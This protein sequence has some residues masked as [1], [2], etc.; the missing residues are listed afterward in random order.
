MIHACRQFVLASVG[1][2]FFITH[3]AGQDRKMIS[4]H[5]NGLTFDQ[6]VQE[7]ETHSDYHFYYTISKADSLTINLEVQEKPLSFVLDQV[8]ANTEFRYAIDDQGNVFITRKYKIETSLPSDFFSKKKAA[9]DSSGTTMLNETGI[10]DESKDEKLK[11]TLEN[12]L[13]LIGVRTNALKAGNAT[14]AGYIRDQKSGESISGAAV[15]IDN[16]PIGVTTDQYGYFSF[17]LPRGRHVLRISSVGMKDTKRQVMLYSDGKLNIELSEF[18]PSLKVVTVISE[19]NSNVKRAQMGVEKLNIKTIKQVP[20]VFGEVDVLRA[21]LALPGVTSVGEASTGFNVRGSAADENLILFNDATI[22]NP[23]HFFGFFSAFNPDVVKDVDLYKSSIPEKFGGRLASVLDITTRD[24]NKK[25]LSGD[26][27]VGPV[28]ARLTLD[29]PIGNEKTT[30]VLGGR[31]TYS[32]WLLKTIPNSDYSN[33]SASF[34]DLNLHIS[35]EI[36]AKNN[37]YLTGYLSQDKFRLNSDTLY[38]YSNKNLNLKWKHNFNN[39]LVSVITGG[40]DGY[41]YSIA[42]QYNPINAYKLSFD[43]NQAYFKADFNFTPNSSHA[44]DFGLSSIFYKL[45]PGSYQPDGAKS[46]VAPD[47]LDQEQ[48]LESALYLGDRFTISPR[49]SLN[50]GIRYSIY[51][52]LGPHDVY[53]YV[54]GQPRE[55]STILDTVS[56]GPGKFIKTYQ[57]PEYRISMRYILSDNSSLKAGYNTL[58]QYIHVLSNTTAISPTDVWKLSDPNISPE[59]GDQFSLGYYQDFKSHNI[60]TSVEIYYKRLHNYLDYKSGAVLIMN[61]HIETD[62]LNTRG[63]AYGAEFMIK[64]LAGK[65]NGWLS[66]TYSR[67]LLQV[68]DPLAGQTINN[69]DFY[70]AN[71]DRPNNANLVGNYKINHRFSISLNVSYSTGRPITLP[72]AIYDLGGSQRVFYSDRNQY[73]IPDYFRT[74]LSMNIEGNHK[75]KKFKHSSWTLGV[76]NLTARKNPYSV[77]FVE[78]NG[79]IKG[80]QLSIFGTAIPFITY[81]FKF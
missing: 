59:Y 57:G 10:G 70:P 72:V 14:I 25:K 66:Y 17:T 62:V 50:A 34:Y 81:N 42:S 30:F 64:K 49:L 46:L 77:Y 74:D 37:L 76:Y 7:I 20:V 75:I 65:L 32:D 67:T 15:Y 27:G 35:H 31:T 71:F 26:G 47:K 45:Q 56:Y 52:Y 39:K 12:K 78:E 8:F 55:V 53:T 6:F 41:A 61:P 44:I 19:K 16:P 51:N 2:L 43:I 1:L 5:F 24:G 58:R 9:S 80:Y 3:S 13:F 36:N 73:R 40:Y 23:S 60:E 38:Q 48:A 68:D 54:P 29:G 69:G 28:T 18:V 4:G 33:S 21:V 11:S 79:V 63:K 22:F